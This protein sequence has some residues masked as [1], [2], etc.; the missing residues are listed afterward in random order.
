M[1]RRAELE[2][3]R[4]VGGYFW[5]HKRKTHAAI[6]LR[7]NFLPLN[8]GCLS[9]LHLSRCASFQCTANLIDGIF[10]TQT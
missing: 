3:V 8:C 1:R 7:D 5:D 10:H 6:V 9:F 4:N 2:S